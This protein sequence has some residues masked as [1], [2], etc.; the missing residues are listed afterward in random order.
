MEQLFA[1]CG[2]Y[3]RAILVNRTQAVCM[4]CGEDKKCLAFDSSDGE[5]ST[6]TFCKKCIEKFFDG[7]ISKSDFSRDLSGQDTLDGSM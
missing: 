3:S 4:E 6:M 5:Y 2:R 7:H 1:A